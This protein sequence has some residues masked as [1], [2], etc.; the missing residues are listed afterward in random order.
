MIITLEQAL[1]LL[2]KASDVCW[3]GRM[4]DSFCVD[5]CDGA[6]FFMW[7]AF[8][9]GDCSWDVAFSAGAN[10]TARIDDNML[11]LQDDDGDDWAFSLVRSYGAA[12][13]GGGIMTRAIPL[14]EVAELLE[15]ASG[16]HWCGLQSTVFSYNGLS[17][18][19]FLALAFEND[20]G[21]QWE[22]LFCAKDNQLVAVENNCLRLRLI[23]GNCVD[24]ELF[25]PTRLDQPNIAASWDVRLARIGSLTPAQL[26]ET[27][28][29]PT[30]H[31]GRSDPALRRRNRGEL[32]ASVMWK[33]TKG[34]TAP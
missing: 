24:I 17:A 12:Q 30:I 13:R 32:I 6:P 26:R 31:R 33:E 2:V 9:E 11:V 16:A 1:A 23:N 10:V 28:Y 34:Y 3:E 20:E 22:F 15:K 18:P 14:S 7:A 8:A 29:D 19:C 21:T 4:A 27:L 5:T 25:A